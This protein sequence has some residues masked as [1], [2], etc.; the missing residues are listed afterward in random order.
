MVRP[1]KT[2]IEAA[3]RIGMAEK[4]FVD[5]I[6]ALADDAKSG[7]VSQ[8]DEI[9]LRILQGRAQAYAELIKLVKEAPTMLRKA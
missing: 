5:F 9:Q 1:D 7:L 4:P 3:A 6:G 8:V 2:V